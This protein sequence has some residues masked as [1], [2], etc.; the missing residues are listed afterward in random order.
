M[1]RYRIDL[2]DDSTLIGK[3]LIPSSLMNQI[4]IGDELTITMIEIGEKIKATVKR[5][6]AVIDPASSTLNIE[7]EI[8][9]KEQK[10]KAGMSGTASFEMNGIKP[11]QIEQGVGANLYQPGIKPSVFYWPKIVEERIQGKEIGERE[12]GR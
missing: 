10:L 4:R 9:N 1:S 5:M 12:K 3:L 2:V 8:D 6:G 7:V 11:A